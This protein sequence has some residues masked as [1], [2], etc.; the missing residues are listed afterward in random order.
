MIKTVQNNIRQPFLADSIRMPAGSPDKKP[1]Q[2]SLRN[3]TSAVLIGCYGIKY[4]M[5]LRRNKTFKYARVAGKFW[6]TDGQDVFIP[7]ARQL[8]VLRGKGVI[9]IL[10][11]GRNYGTTELRTQ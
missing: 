8:P 2:N 10:A 9:Q 3:H 7:A 11:N 1:L 4:N 5:L 6:S